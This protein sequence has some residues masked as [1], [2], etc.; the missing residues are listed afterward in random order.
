M[1]GNKNLF[2]S[3]IINVICRPLSMIIGLFNTPLVLRYLGDEKYGI[4]VTMSSILNWISVFDIGIGNGLRN[5][6]TAKYSRQKTDEAQSVVSSAYYLLGGIICVLFLLSLCICLAVNWNIVFKSQINALPAIIIC[7]VFVCINFV[8]SL[9]KNEYFA[10]QK[11]EIVSA[12]GIIIQIICLFGII[13]LGYYATDKL[14]SMA[15]L[16]GIAAFSVNIFFSILIWRKHSYFIPYPSKI[17]REFIHEVCNIGLKFFVLQISA[18]ILFTTD[19]IIISLLYGAEVV[20]TYSIPFTIFG[21]INGAFMAFLAPFWSKYT[22]KKEQNDWLWIKKAMKWLHVLLIPFVLLV[23]FVVLF[24]DIITQLWIGRTINYAPYLIVSLGAYCFLQMYS[25]IYS[26]FLAGIGNINLQ[27]G[28]SLASA[29][30]NIPLSIF[31]ARNCGLGPTGVC[32]ATVIGF[33][34]GAVVFTIQVNRIFVRNKL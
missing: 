20:T 4:W 28:I 9:Q 33:A 31:L 17:K 32:L 5:I 25:A 23:V 30:V 29:V 18:L 27:L 10:I 1:E 2:Q 24:F 26:T 6:L 13:I 3:I 15:L 8:A 19:N 12:S 7:L 16:T 11:S 22:E 14:V 34:A 21:V